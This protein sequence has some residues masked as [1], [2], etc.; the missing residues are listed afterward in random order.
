MR[1]FEKYLCNRR[2]NLKK[3]AI[4]FPL[5]PDPGSNILP[6]GSGSRKQYFAPWIQI[7]EAI[8]CPL[9]PDPDSESLNLSDPTDQDQDPDPKRCF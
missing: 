5:D 9:D 1:K 6:L 2:L 8:F 3:E 4:F 7:Q